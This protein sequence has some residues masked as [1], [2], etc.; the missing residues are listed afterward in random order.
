[1]SRILVHDP[2]PR[3]DDRPALFRA[4]EH[5]VVCCRDREALVC[6]LSERRADLLVY[7]LQDIARDV[8]F[9]SALRQSAPR[10]PLILLGEPATLEVRR[11]VQDLKPTYY[12]VFPLEGQELAEAVH[13]VLGAAAAAHR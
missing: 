10:L 8:A 11:L 6:A 7:V 3:I 2:R 5:D 1:M 4:P 12:G 9:L 13:A